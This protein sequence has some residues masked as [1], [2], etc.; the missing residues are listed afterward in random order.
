MWNYIK[1]KN[2][3]L[4][5]VISIFSILILVGIIVYIIIDKTSSKTAREIYKDNIETIVEVKAFNDDGISYGTG[6]IYDKTGLIITN[7]HIVV[8][9]VN[10]VDTIFKE[11][12]IRFQN[13]EEYKTTKLIKY[14]LILDLAILSI[15]DENNYQTVSLSKGSY[16]TGDTVFAIGN[17]LNQGIGITSGIISLKEVNI[18]N[19]GNTRKVIQVDIN[20]TYGNSGGA[21]FDVRGKL[22]GITTFRIK[23]DNGNVNYGFTYCIPIDIIKEYIKEN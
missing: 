14:D 10:D 7:A 4:T 9:T 17:S 1:V 2:K 16:N 13:D 15:E 22:I 21:L 23:D 20:I 18:I 12:Q 8:Y 11:I 19:S 3:K 6:V 5:Q